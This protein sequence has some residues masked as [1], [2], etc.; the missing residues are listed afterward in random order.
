MKF[1]ETDSVNR[2]QLLAITAGLSVPVVAGCLGDDGDEE[3]DEEP[4]NGADEPN[5]TEN[6]TDDSDAEPSPND[7]DDD[8]GDDEPTG[9]PLFEPAIVAIPESV[10]AGEAFT[11]EFT[12]ENTGDGPGRTTAV[13]TF[14]ETEYFSSDVSLDPGEAT[15]TS[16]RKS[17]DIDRQESISVT[18]SV[19]EHQVSRTVTIVDPTAEQF[20]MELVGGFLSVEGETVEEAREATF[21]IDLSPD[22]ELDEAIMLEAQRVGGRWESTHIELP[23]LEVAGIH[24]EPST[25]DGLAGEF[26][27]DAGL[28][29]MEG[30]WLFDFGAGELDTAFE[31]TTGDSGGM[32]GSFDVDEEPPTATLV[33]NE[34]GV[35][36]SGFAPIDNELDMPL[37]PGEVWLELI[38]EFD[39]I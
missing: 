23:D 13:L 31:A 27:P 36:E 9:E 3:T 35:G 10:D 15:T 29:T 7:D 11:V 32:T 37:E 21:S 38:V 16:V 2:R 4:A 18:L 28:M 33:D 39:G 5:D 20:S 34:S 12:I 26:D 8:N 1:T 19:G 6:G 30:R 24:V 25:P 22:G 17:L 14:D